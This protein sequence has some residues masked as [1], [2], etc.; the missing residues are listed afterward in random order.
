MWRELSGSQLTLDSC[1]HKRLQDLQLLNTEHF[2]VHHDIRHV[3]FLNSSEHVLNII[4]LIT[5]EKE[6]GAICKTT[7]FKGLP[8]IFLVSDP[9]Y[10]VSFSDWD[11]SD[12]YINLFILKTV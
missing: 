1:H 12:V 11:K 4:S 8:L 3:S 2:K 6:T 5:A 10:S 9:F 7:D